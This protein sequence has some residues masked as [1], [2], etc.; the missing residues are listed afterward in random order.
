MCALPLDRPQPA[1]DSPVPDDADLVRV[2]LQPGEMSLHHPD[3]LHGSAPN[4]SPAKR[5]GFVIR[6]ASPQAQPLGSRPRVVPVR[7]QVG[8][9]RFQIAPPPSA[10]DAEL[11]LAALKESAAQHFD[12]V[13]QNLRLAKR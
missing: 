2:T 13:L 3:I 6:Y 11:A 8:H 5:V 4:L 9:D 7:G 1:G 12:V 10:S